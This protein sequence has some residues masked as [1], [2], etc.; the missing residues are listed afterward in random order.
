MRVLVTGGSGVVGAGTVTELLKR[1][2]EVRLLARHADDDARQWASGVTPI[3]GDV[4]DVAS[5]R[6][7][8]DGCDVEPK[9][10]FRQLKSYCRQECP[11]P[12]Y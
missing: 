4:T 11:D 9:P 8:A 1:G 10:C 12:K 6:G 3:V 7:A 5:I 2:H